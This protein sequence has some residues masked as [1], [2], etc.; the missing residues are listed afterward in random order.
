MDKDAVMKAVGE[1]VEG[2]DWFVAGRGDQPEPDDYILAFEETM[3]EL[4]EHAG[5]D[6]PKEKLGLALAFS[7]TNRGE[8]AS[9]RRAMKKYTNSTVFVD[10]NIHLLL[11][12]DDDSVLY[13]SA[14]R[15]NEFL[16]DLNSYV[17]GMKKQSED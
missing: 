2:G 12:R 14:E 8:D 1:W 16:E 10:L 13:I 5:G 6:A 7:S 15:V 3:G 17:A 9:Y 4:V 11:V